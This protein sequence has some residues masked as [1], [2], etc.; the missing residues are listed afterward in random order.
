VNEDS[1]SILSRLS[2]LEQKIDRLL[3]RLGEG[4]E[5]HYDLS[6][7]AKSVIQM[8]LHKRQLT[9]GQQNATKEHGRAE[10]G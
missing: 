8:K 9:N 4:T 1:R 6:Q 3:Y 5:N 2:I 7:R 10:K